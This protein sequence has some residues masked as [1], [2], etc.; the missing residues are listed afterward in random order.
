[1][2]PRP[3]VREAARTH[4]VAAAVLVDQ[5]TERQLQATVQQ[6]ATLHG[7]RWY[8]THDS[9]RS[10]PGYPDLTLVHPS[11]GRLI[12]AELKTSRG[13]LT[14]DQKAWIADLEAAGQEVHVWRPAH[15]HD[16]TINTTLT[17]RASTRHVS[18]RATLGSVR[19][20]R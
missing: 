6:L 5:M 11:Q 18:S 8:H 10:V 19:P 1:M 16:G 20:T 13:R 17:T 14:K 9:R 3:G 12:F 4:S 2:I 7:W 15:L